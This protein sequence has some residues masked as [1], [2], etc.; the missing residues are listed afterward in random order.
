[1]STLKSGI[2]QTQLSRYRLSNLWFKCKTFRI[3]SYWV[4]L[5]I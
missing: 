1:M 4:Y 3:L 5:P 2:K